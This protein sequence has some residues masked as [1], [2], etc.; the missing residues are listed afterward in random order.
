MEPFTTVTAFGTGLAVLTAIFFPIIN[1]FHEK[2]NK[3]GNLNVT[4]MQWD[5]ESKLFGQHLAKITTLKV[6]PGFLKNKHPKKPLVL[7]FHGLTGTGKNYI[8]QI[9]A[10]HIYPDGLK[11]KFVHQFVATLHFP[12]VQHLDMYKDQLQTWIKRNVSACERSVFIFDEVDKMQPELIDAIK[13]YLDYY[14]HIEGV[15]Y[16]KA[17]FIFLSNTGGEVILG[18]A[19]DFRKAGKQREDIKMSDVEHH[20]SLAAFNKKDGGFWHSSL[21]AQNL[22]DYFVPF[23]PL[24]LQ[25]VKMCIRRAIL[26]R[27]YIIEEDIV[28]KVANDMTYYPKDEKVFSVKGCKVKDSKSGY[29]FHAGIL[30]IMPLYANSV[31]TIARC[32]E[33]ITTGIAIATASALT[34]YLSSP[35]FYCR[36][37]ECCEEDRPFNATA[38]EADLNKKIFGQHLANNII[39]RALNG[40]F[41]NP[42]PKKPLALSLH[43][44]TGTGKNFISKIIADNMYP[45]GMES[46]FIHLFISTLHFPHDSKIQLYKDQLQSWIRGNVS[47]CERSLF[48]FDEMDKLHPGLVDA[49]KPYLDYYDHIDGVSYRKAVFIF[50]RWILAQHSD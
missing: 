29:V 22:I 38:L 9:I 43:G 47:K 15:D 25:H 36:F 23:L 49:I 14:E 50:L 35:R 44:W 12:H 19:L 42:N 39:L 11:S 34:G 41:S 17:I 20:L 3:E 31:Y 4:A 48:I 2:C 13:P 8:S 18:L 32:L 30:D 24:E 16:R 5:F 40:F 27:G 10:Q 37:A 46:K 33:P 1:P 7:S 6:L 45:L 28:S 26:D 21:I